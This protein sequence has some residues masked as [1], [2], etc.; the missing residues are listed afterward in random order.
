ME[1]NNTVTL[2]GYVCEKPNFSHKVYGEGFYSFRLKVDRL[3]ENCDFIPVMVSERLLCDCCI[4]EGNFIKVTGQFRSYNNYSEENGNRLILM[5]FAR[6]IE[7]VCEDDCSNPN[8]IIL[9]GFICKP[10]V[11]RTT[12]FGREISDILIAVNR[13]YNKSDYIPAIA[14]GRNAHFCSRLCVGQNVKIY[15]RVQ[16]REYQKKIEDNVINKTAYEISI[17]KLEIIE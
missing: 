12:P 11:Y 6:E 13:S 8:E 7:D 15:G 1:C 17:S 2:K 3:S 10:P 14:W 16:S 5:V 4:R 9:N